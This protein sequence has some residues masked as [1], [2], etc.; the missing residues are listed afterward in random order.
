MGNTND[1][2]HELQTISPRLASIEKLNIFSVPHGYFENLK[3][4]V[5][6]FIFVILAG[7]IAFFIIGLN[8]PNQK[9]Y[10]VFT[11]SGLIIL[12]ILFSLYIIRFHND[13]IQTISKK[14]FSILKKVLLYE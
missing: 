10:T 7:I 4:K 13:L 9:N 2:L 5:I 1:I 6:D 12:G 3:E 14:I 11:I 8:N